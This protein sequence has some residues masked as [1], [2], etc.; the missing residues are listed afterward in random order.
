MPTNIA[1][2]CI[3]TITYNN[4]LYVV[5][6]YMYASSYSFCIVNIKFYKIHTASIAIAIAI[7]IAI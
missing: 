4:Y 1:M 3:I 2:S 6:A 5:I 7:R